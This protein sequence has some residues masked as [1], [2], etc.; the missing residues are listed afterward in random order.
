[1]IS[2]E[3][4]TQQGSK[5]LRAKPYLVDYI[6]THVPP[7]SLTAAIFFFVLNITF[8]AHTHNLYPTSLYII[9]IL[10]FTYF[11]FSPSSFIIIYLYMFVL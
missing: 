11:T 6:S 10:G 1:M 3:R 9:E 8:Y 7:N 4:V 2:I 5:D